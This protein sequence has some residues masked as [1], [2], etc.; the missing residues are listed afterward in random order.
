MQVQGLEQAREVRCSSKSRRK[1]ELS[2]DDETCFVFYF[3]PRW[4]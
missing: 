1:V 4:N 2:E 3:F